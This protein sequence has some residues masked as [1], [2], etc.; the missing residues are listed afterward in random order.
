MCFTHDAKR[1][2]IAC[3]SVEFEIESRATLCFSALEIFDNSERMEWS[4]ERN[5]CGDAFLQ[6]TSTNY[7]GMGNIDAYNIYAR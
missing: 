1:F 5:V 7:A 3:N 4:K 2:V 6:L